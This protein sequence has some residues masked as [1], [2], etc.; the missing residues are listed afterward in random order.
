MKVDPTALANGLN[1]GYER[2]SK[3]KITPEPWGWNH[4]Q[5]TGQEMTGRRDWRRRPEVSFWTC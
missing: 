4:H 5:M 2:K 3:E 1:V